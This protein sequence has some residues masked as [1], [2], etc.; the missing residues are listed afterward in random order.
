MAVSQPVITGTSTDVN[1]VPTGNRLST[2]TTKGAPRPISNSLEANVWVPTDSLV[3][4]TSSIYKNV[5]YEPDFVGQIF[6]S[7]AFGDFSSYTITETSAQ[8]YIAVPY[9]WITHVTLPRLRNDLIWVPVILDPEV[10]YKDPA[11]GKVWDPMGAYVC[12]P[13]YL[14]A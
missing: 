1:Y 12:N 7:A 2:F 4:T 11:T 13:P 10:S 6:W 9:T 14:C 3:A 8:L 5:I